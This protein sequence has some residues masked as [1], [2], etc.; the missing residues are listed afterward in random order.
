MSVELLLKETT[1]TA[2]AILQ[3]LEE[4]GIG[5][6]FGI[7]GGHTGRLF[8]ALANHQ[9]AIRTVL[10]REESL[11]GVKLPISADSRATSMRR[12]TH[13]QKCRSCPNA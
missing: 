8:I 9:N 11:A 2:D 10:V 1:R 6:V 3:V 12:H 5:M 7:A 4:A 13:L